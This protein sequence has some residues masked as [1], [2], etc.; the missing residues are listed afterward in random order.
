MED[1]INFIN[2]IYFEILKE[3]NHQ[4]N[5]SWNGLYFSTYLFPFWNLYHSFKLIIQLFTHNLLKDIK[6][7]SLSWIAHNFYVVFQIIFFLILL[8]NI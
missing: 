8:Q 4:L 1:I 7:S 6:F 3:L 2:F 5:M